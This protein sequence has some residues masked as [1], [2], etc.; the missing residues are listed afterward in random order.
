[1]GTKQSTASSYSRHIP[2]VSM[3]YNDSGSKIAIIDGQVVHEGSVI[4]GYK[5]VK[6]EKIRVLART[7]GKEIWLSLE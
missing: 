5:I 6:I 4:T 1:M 2:E 3:I 7:N